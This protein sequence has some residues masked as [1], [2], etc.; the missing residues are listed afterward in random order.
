MYS[1][2]SGKRVICD[3]KRNTCGFSILIN[4]FTNKIIISLGGT[5]GISQHF[6]QGMS[7]FKKLKNFY[8]IGLVNSYFAE[9][10]EYL[11]KYIKDVFEVQTYEDYKVV[12]T[13]HSLG[14]ALAALIA[15]RIQL[16]GIRESHDIFLYTFGEP[17]VG[18]HNFAMNFDKR[19]IN[20]W[21]VVYAT[22]FIAHIPSCKKVKRTRFKLSGRRTNLPCD[23]HSRSGYYHHGTE[24]WYPNTQSFRNFYRVCLGY[25]PNEDFNCSDHMNFHVHKY[26]YHREHHSLY[27]ID[28]YN[29]YPHIFKSN[30]G[31]T[32]EIYNRKG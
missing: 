15:L 20:S 6:R 11:W 29:I 1:C 21:R 5:V 18:T 10:H 17:R 14:G 3:K 4:T 2:Y 32:C 30:Y 31:K 28:L 8:G 19:V 24:V 16:E 27:F 13:G 26:S 22:D 25:P 12:V 9:T 23:P 7:I